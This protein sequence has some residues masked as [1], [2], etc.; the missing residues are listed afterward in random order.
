MDNIEPKIHK[1]ETN[2]EMYSEF[3]CSQRETYSSLSF[4]MAVWA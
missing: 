4:F 3:V 1:K 2:P